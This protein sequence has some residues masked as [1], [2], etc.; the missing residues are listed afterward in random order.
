MDNE[1]IIRAQSAK[2]AAS[3]VLGRSKTYRRLF[4]YL[5]ENSLAGRAPKELEIATDVFAKAVDFDPTQDSM[6]RVYA[7]NL[8]QK[9]KQFYDAAGA[10]EQDRLY[11]PR[12]EYRL[13]VE[14][15][16][17]APPAPPRPLL[18]RDARLWSAFLVAAILFAAGFG[19]CRFEQASTTPSVATTPLWSAIADDDL[20][21]L[22]VVGDYFI[23]GEIDDR[24][25][26]VRFVREFS[27]NSAADLAGFRA[28]Y[29]DLGSH[30]QNLNTTYL[31]RSTATAL[32][33]VLRV[34][35]SLPNRNVEVVTMSE[36]DPNDVRTSH[37]VYIGY[38]SALDELF[39]FAFAG[40]SLAIGETFDELWNVDTGQV[41]TSD[42]GRPADYRN[43]R[44]YG[45]FSTFPGPAGNQFVIIA[46]TRDE[47]VLHS[48]EAAS[49]PHYVEAALPAI[50]AADP[51][52]F[53]LLYEVTGF[54]RTH[55][56]A[57]LV[58]SGP[59]DATRIWR[60]SLSQLG[61]ST[62]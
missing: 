53:E 61:G 41:F 29:P 30:Y 59:I 17:T 14:S 10:A 38:F 27:V 32:A 4:E 23:L 51:S 57:M 50:E 12:G 36:F 39:D 56:D 34:L 46:G 49:D 19:F 31:A 42:A 47:G 25:D 21:I 1:Q 35:D 58:H 3:G 45:Y 40:S 55:I 26:V 5:V 44:D 37:I 52:Q 60:G 43:Y 54:D 7:H 2:I 48:A 6:V 24:G 22:V 8:R 28:R 11:I 62:N 20:P 15:V 33:D 13:A 9:L 18:W 16:E